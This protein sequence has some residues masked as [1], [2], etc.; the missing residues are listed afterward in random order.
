MRISRFLLVGLLLLSILTSSVS[1][2][3]LFFGIARAETTYN[4]N[5][6]STS[7]GSVI[8]PGV[9]LFPF[10]E[11]A[12]VTLKVAPDIGYQFTGWT[13][14]VTTIND[15]HALVTFIL[16]SDNYTI[17]ANFTPLPISVTI[18]DNG[19]SGLSFGTLA[20]GVD[21]RPEIASPSITIKNDGSANV[22]VSLM[23][24]N[25]TVGAGIITINNAFYNDTDDSGTALA[26][27]TSYTQWRT[28]AHG[29]T[30]DIYH[31]LSIPD[32]TPPGT[33]SST[34]TYKTQDAS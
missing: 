29:E 8:Q 23:G 5:I 1:Q 6:S 28:L 30:L 31:W 19:A 3:F 21:K 10:E 4:L 32:R 24:T 17:T 12:N 9:G 34:F 7:G 2:I 20:S 25:F 11:S 33:Y 15:T 16:M 27:S 13:G 14:D 26:M 18:T 22:T